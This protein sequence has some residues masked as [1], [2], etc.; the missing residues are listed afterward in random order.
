[1]KNKPFII[2]PSP[3]SQRDAKALTH[4][5]LK[6][7]RFFKKGV[8]QV[9]VAHRLKVSRAAVHYWYTTW[10]KYGEEGLR[11]HGHPGP[12]S[13]LTPDKA[14]IITRILLRGAGDAGYA[15][16]LWT[17]PRIAEV[18]KKRTHISYHP[19]HVWKVIHALGFTCQKPET[20]YR[21]RNEAAI[22]RWKEQ[23]WPAIQK[24]G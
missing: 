2:H 12:Q 17:L 16:E 6:A 23:R 22:K 11:S 9:E 1:M 14:R 20:R 8:R 21:N 18:M 15:T 24:R 3:S 10:K 13:K 19:G 5:R 7:A 4:R